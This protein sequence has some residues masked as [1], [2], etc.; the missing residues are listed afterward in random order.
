MDLVAARRDE[1]RVDGLLPFVGRQGLV[2]EAHVEPFLVPLGE[3][4][5]LGAADDPNHICGTQA[6]LGLL[7][8]MPS[9]V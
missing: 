3:V 9:T 6:V 4:G 2:R 7:E 5:E 1:R 8:P